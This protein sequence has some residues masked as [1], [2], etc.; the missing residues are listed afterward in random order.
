MPMRTSSH[1]WL[2]GGQSRSPL[3]AAISEIN[4]TVVQLQN[5]SLIIIQQ[6]IK[7]ELLKDLLISMFKVKGIIEINDDESNIEN[8]FYVDGNWCVEH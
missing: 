5:R 8:K 3:R 7:I 4:K 2:S 1:H 6:K